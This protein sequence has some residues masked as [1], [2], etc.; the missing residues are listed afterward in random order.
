MEN[1]HKR[2][3]EIKFE[4]YD[5]D[6]FNNKRNLLN[7]KELHLVQ[8]NLTKYF[9]IFELLFIFLINF[10]SLLSKYYKKNLSKAS[11]INLKVKGVGNINF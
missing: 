7:K 1:D 2:K 3:K 10:S 4:K 6:F 5:K 11:E 8:F 9:S